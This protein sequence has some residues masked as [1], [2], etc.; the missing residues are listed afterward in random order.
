LKT[1]IFLIFIAIESTAAFGQ[2][3]RPKPPAFTPADFEA[4]SKR[5]AYAAYLEETCASSSQVQAGY[6]KLVTA[7]EE[8]A[9]RQNSYLTNFRQ[10]KNKHAND[11]NAVVIAKR[12]YWELA[13]SKSLVSDVVAELEQATQITERKRAQ[14]SDAVLQWEREQRE[15]EARRQREQQEAEL[16]RAKEKNDA[17]EKIQREYREQLQ[18]KA[19]SLSA[20]LGKLVVF[21][22]YS[23]GADIGVQLK[24]YS[25]NQT[26]KMMTMK[27]EIR[28][29]GKF[30]GDSYGADGVIKATYDSTD[31]WE[32]SKNYF[33]N[34]SWLSSSLQSYLKCYKTLFGRCD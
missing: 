15:I 5:A 7:T 11:S 23:G 3:S 31:S 9:D 30:S 25:Y 20:Q 13:K 12:C 21:G 8:N 14:H 28:W 18:A 34:P 29:S 17:D 24:D 2:S 16:R 26:E 19:E 22:K 27:V 6:K 1:I 33:W 32:L 10:I 4:Q